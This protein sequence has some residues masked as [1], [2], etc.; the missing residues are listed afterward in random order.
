M[1][2]GD[3]RELERFRWWHLLGRTVFSLSLIDP[4]RGKVTYTVD[5]RH[6]GNP[7]GDQV[8]VSLY[9]DDKQR[10]RSRLPAAFP[11]PGGHIEVATS[12]FGMRRCHFVSTTGAERPLL[13]D[14]RSAEGRRARLHHAH[15][16]LSRYIGWVS[17]AMPVAGIGLNLV[18]VLEPLS[19]VAPIGARVV[20]FESPLR[21]PL[22]LN[23]ALGFGAVL[24]STERGL[25]LR[26]SRLLDGAA[27]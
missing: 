9:L 19:Q 1:R 3:G 27:N 7:G 2:A 8:E 12:A 4:D 6:L 17:V 20:R 24:A 18:Q 14:S 26:Y 16:T 10:A 15:P 22:W 25:R 5:V 13:P 11:V 23:L 21:L